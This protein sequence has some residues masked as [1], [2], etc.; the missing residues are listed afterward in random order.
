[1]PTQSDR[2]V[3]INRS[4]I[5]RAT[6]VTLPVEVI[7]IISVPSSLQAKCCRHSCRRGLYRA[8]VSPVCGSTPALRACLWPLQAEQA[9][10]RF[11]SAVAPP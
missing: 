8:T 9:R 2:A 7:P 10:H 6:T 1:M 4:F 11:S 5:S 3:I